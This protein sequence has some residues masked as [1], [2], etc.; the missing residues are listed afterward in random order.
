MFIT[1]FHLHP[2]KVD[3]C[4]QAGNESWKVNYII[5]SQECALFLAGIENV[6][7]TDCIPIKDKMNF[8][9]RISGTR[10]SYTEERSGI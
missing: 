5:I 6:W 2:Y 10:T 4:D 3:F 9:F 7:T 8:Q 1:D